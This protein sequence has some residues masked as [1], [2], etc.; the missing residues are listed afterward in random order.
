MKSLR[1]I[2]WCL[3]ALFAGASAYLWLAQN[4]TQQFATQGSV[5]IDGP[6]NL[7]TNKGA[8][9]T[10][11]ALADRPHALFFGFTHCPD[12][13]PTTLF[14]AAGWLKEMGAEGEN[15]DFYF[16][17]VDP[18]RDTPEILNDYVGAFDARIIGVTGTQEEMDKA[19]KSY[20]VYA[21]RVELEDDDYTMD[22]S[23]AVLLFRSDG[24]LQG[25]ISY[26]ENA[27]TAIAK[28]RRLVNNS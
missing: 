8:A 15:L 23:A 14:E 28:L 22:H 21:K 10:Q 17:T 13:C 24:S 3:V 5:K 18:E 12:I 11:A 7:V 27:E 19:L 16:F 25:T 4:Q 20:R 26:G 2:L 9:I 6:F 1:I